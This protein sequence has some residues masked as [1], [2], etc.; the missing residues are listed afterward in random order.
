MPSA[1]GTSAEIDEEWRL[2][3][4]AM[5]PATDDLHLAVSQRFFAQGQRAQGD[6]HVRTGDFKGIEAPTEKRL[7]EPSVP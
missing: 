1:P 7:S 6:L 2:I 5:T 3:Q 4:V